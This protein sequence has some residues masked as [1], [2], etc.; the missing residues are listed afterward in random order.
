M[1][2]PSAQS[3][4]IMG[5]GN[6][7]SR[8]NSRNKMAYLCKI[9]MH[10][11][12]HFN[13]FFSRSMAPRQTLKFKFRYK[14][15]GLCST[16]LSSSTLKNCPEVDLYLAILH[17]ITTNAKHLNYHPN[18]VLSTTYISQAASKKELNHIM[19]LLPISSFKGGRSF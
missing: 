6:K 13:K 12:W 15:S 2:R 17:Q 5:P 8:P 14:N 18:N 7:W 10:I 3:V 1:M 19:S 16:P 9:Y 4:I 11:F